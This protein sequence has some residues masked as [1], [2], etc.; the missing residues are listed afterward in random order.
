M[1]TDH[2]TCFSLEQACGLVNIWLSSPSHVNNVCYI[3]SEHSEGSWEMN[4]VFKVVDVLV[5]ENL[6]TRNTEQDETKVK[7]NKH[8]VAPYRLTAVF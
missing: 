1:F 8:I 6:S 2:A 3:F 5:C 4:V 7:T